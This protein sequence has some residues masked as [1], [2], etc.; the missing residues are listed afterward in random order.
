MWLSGHH[1]PACKCSGN[2]M[3]RKKQPAPMIMPMCGNPGHDHSEP[4]KNKKHKHKNKKP[5]YESYQSGYPTNSY[6]S[7]NTAQD[8]Y[9]YRRR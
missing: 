5:K 3:R 4:K 1:S 2:K 7:Q 9:P 8:F 6:G